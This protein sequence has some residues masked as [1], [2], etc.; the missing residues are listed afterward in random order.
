MPSDLAVLILMTKSNLVA[1]C[2]GRSP[3][4]SSSMPPAGGLR[5][6]SMLLH[7]TTFRARPIVS[8]AALRALMAE[9][10][11]ACCSQGSKLR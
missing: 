6:P 10:S 2:T 3:G 5:C 4:F 11:G 8:N 1:C 9:L 7:L